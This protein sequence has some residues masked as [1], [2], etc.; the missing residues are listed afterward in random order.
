MGL[1]DP[2]EVK[3]QIPSFYQVESVK[4]RVTM[5]PKVLGNRA[6]SKSQEEGR[7]HPVEL[8]TLAWLGSFESRLQSIPAV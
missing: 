2:K 1:A 5:T 7:R 6:G 3:S 4:G 8:K